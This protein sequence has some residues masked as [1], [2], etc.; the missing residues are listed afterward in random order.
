MVMGRGRRADN[1]VSRSSVPRSVVDVPWR[2]TGAT[3]RD[4][5]SRPVRGQPPGLGIRPQ[6]LPDHHLQWETPGICACYLKQVA[7]CGG[8]HIGRTGARWS[9][10]LDGDLGS[11]DDVR[12]R[13]A[14]LVEQASI[15]EVLGHVQ[16]R[17][18][19]GQT[20]Q[21]VSR[22][23]PNFSLRAA[24]P[25]PIRHSREPLAQVRPSRACRARWHERIP[26]PIGRP[27]RANSRGDSA[28]DNG[29]L[30]RGP[31]G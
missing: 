20:G 27:N 8:R 11:I 3:E 5:R 4:G 10:L 6:A 13:L 26:A 16:P 21:Q 15:A 17:L 19:L 28:L 25:V 7:G 23:S 9:R 31:I 22:S 2:R 1:C 12:Y 30:L 18:V 24:T 14:D 29:P